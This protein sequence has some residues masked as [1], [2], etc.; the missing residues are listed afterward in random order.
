MVESCWWYWFICW[1][2]WVASQCGALLHSATPQYLLFSKAL[3][4]PSA[5]ILHK[6]CVWIVSILIVLESLSCKIKQMKFYLQK[7]IPNIFCGGLKCNDHSNWI[8]KCLFNKT[9]NATLSWVRAANGGLYRTTRWTTIHKRLPKS[10]VSWH[11]GAGSFGKGRVGSGIVKHHW[12]ETAA[13][14]TTLPRQPMQ[15]VWL[16]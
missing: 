15:I 13:S 5:Q 3:F 7:G 8:P 9:C 11:L 16:I 2:Y 10:N 14:V 1:W 6:A 4:T 12:L